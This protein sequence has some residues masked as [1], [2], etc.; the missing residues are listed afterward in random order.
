MKTKK[1]FIFIISS[2]NKLKNILLIDLGN[3][4]K[5]GPN[6]PLYAE[7]IWI[8]PS[9]CQFRLTGLSN[10]SGK[11]VK[12]WPPKK[13]NRI[14]AVAASYRI[15]S[16]KKR[17][18]YGEPW[19]ATTDYKKKMQKLADRGY[20]WDGDCYSEKELLDKY[21]ALDDIFKQVKKEGKIKTGKELD[22]GIFRE[23]ETYMIHIGPEGELYLGGKGYHRFAMA[24]VLNLDLVPAQIGCVHKNA[25]PYL[26]Y[27]RKGSYKK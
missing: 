17:W 21:K 27:L 8:N 9:D 22:P 26:P 18:V 5:Y 16:C 1:I 4:I 14:T 3:K 12:K 2:I 13:Y 7:R 6:A 15:T 24:L 20:A 19:E 23:S 10:Y 25:I 11:V